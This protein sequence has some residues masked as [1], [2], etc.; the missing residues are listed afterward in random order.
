MAS[1]LPTRCFI[2]YSRTDS[3][4]VDRLEADL[5]ARG[6]ETWVDRRRL[7]GAHDW[8][9]EI[10]RG[11]DWCSLMIVVLSPDAAR[12][13]A[14][15]R[16]YHYALSKNKLVIP[17]LWRDCHMPSELEKI[18]WVDFHVV[19]HA[20]GLKTLLIAIADR[21]DQR[22]SLPTDSRELYKQAIEARQRGDLERAAILLQ[23]LVDH[24]PGYANGEATRDLATVIEQLY[25]ERAQRLRQDATDARRKGEYG[26]EAGILEALVSL[27]PEDAWAEEYL[28]IA[29]RNR[30]QLE[31]YETVQS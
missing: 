10:F 27:G 6:F 17:L 13:D 24:E 22:T 19:D 1:T 23:R 11:V 3:A 7:E 28:P 12:S 25:A 4:F 2:S 15:G 16:E 29:W 31:L 5:R 26:R 18:Q 21:A 14:V 8:E 9:Q 30:K 20:A